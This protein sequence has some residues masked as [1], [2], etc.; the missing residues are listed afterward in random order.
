MLA[1][2][3][4]A[5][6]LS[7]LLFSTAHA[8]FSDGSE[9][10][11]NQP[12]GSYAGDGTVEV[13]PIEVLPTE[14]WRLDLGDVLAG[15]VV[16]DQR[17]Y[18]A[19]ANGSRR[20][21]LVSIE[22]ESGEVEAR[23]SLTFDGP[24]LD[25]AVWKDVLVVVAEHETKAF[26]LSGSRFKTRWTID[27]DL[28]APNIQKGV[29]FARYD[30][31]ERNSRARIYSLEDG[32]VLAELGRCESD[33]ISMVFAGTRVWMLV[34]DGFNR[35]ELRKANFNFPDNPSDPDAWAQAVHVS[36]QLLYHEEQLEEPMGDAV[37]MLPPTSYKPE[38]IW[39]KGAGARLIGVPAMSG[40]YSVE[41][42]PAPVGYSGSL[43]GI[44]PDGLT[45]VLEDGRGGTIFERK[46]MPQGTVLPDGERGVLSRAQN[47]LYMGNVGYDLERQRVLWVAPGIEGAWGLVPAGD[48][49]ALHV[50]DKGELVLYE[51]TE[52]AAAA[53][54]TAIVTR[55]LVEP[56]RL[57]DELEGW[58]LN[59]ASVRLTAD[60]APAEHDLAI[61]LG[62]ADSELLGSEYAT[63]V[64]W[65]ARALGRHASA[66]EPVFEAYLD[67]R[68]VD[69]AERLLDALEA[70]TTAAGLHYAW[71]ADARRAVDNHDGKRRE[72]PS[73]T[74]DANAKRELEALAGL[75]DDWARAALWADDRG[76]QH[77]TA[78]ALIEHDLAHNAANW[79]RKQFA[80]SRNRPEAAPREH[81]LPGG[82]TLGSTVSHGFPRMSADKIRDWSH[83]VQALA[84]A[85]ARFL[86]PKEALPDDAEEFFKG[87]RS[88][89]ALRTENVLLLT[90]CTQPELIGKSLA[91]AEGIVQVLNGLFAPEGEH[92]PMQ[93]RLYDSL[94]SYLVANAHRG[95]D[96]TVLGFYTP[97]ERIA[98]FYVPDQG[99][100][101]VDADFARAE[102]HKV[103]VH[104]LTHQYLQERACPESTF[105]LEREGYWLVEGIANY[106]QDQTVELGRHGAA[107]A[108]A[109]NDATVLSVEVAKRAYEKRRRIKLKDLLTMDKYAFHELSTHVVLRFAPRFQGG[110]LGLNKVNIFY[111]QSAALVFFLM[112][113]T[114]AEGRARFIEFV[115]RWYVGDLTDEPWALL[116]FESVDA[117]E[118]AFEAFLETT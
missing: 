88:E 13:A 74:I 56:D 89:L 40:A 48:R 39:F 116:G 55:E 81:E 93:V 76:L 47:V 62:D 50:T 26:E 59:D 21:Q 6:L 111:D 96:S 10:Y 73:P 102:L 100:S 12:R 11:W 66:L 1:R 103:L 109:L 27:D 9:G 31:H 110:E 45:A 44:D 15:P 49:R 95:V 16:W 54:G 77:T 87:A 32:E 70:R 37:L 42:A 33:P 20:V 85:N 14:R 104:E 71:I 35:V 97:A 53:E 112:T 67:R 61:P 2:S 114:G 90:T 5:A 101:T 29:L 113:Q 36:S 17:A 108:E 105:D 25:I 118:D 19:I 117:L 115:R 65:Q 78:L 83:W 30:T 28:G 46:A 86:D 72:V 51:Q 64:A 107:H 58:L 63:F 24:V 106:F 98:R 43:F 69:E 91:H 99:T 79:F 7:T 3:L 94:E 22:L 84:P 8:Q 82:L 18:F 4:L 38:G 34:V 23:T 80:F 57:P 52:G 92:E 68:F 60:G 75:A 41:Y